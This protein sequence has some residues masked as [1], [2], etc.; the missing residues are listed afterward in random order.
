M[1]RCGIRTPP[2]MLASA[3]FCHVCCLGRWSAAVEAE[4]ADPKVGAFWFQPLRATNANERVHNVPNFV[5]VV[6][7]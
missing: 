3:H 2:K 1:Q 4:D 5:P 6:E 7:T